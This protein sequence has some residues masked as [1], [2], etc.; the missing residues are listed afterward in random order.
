MI[1]MLFNPQPTV[2]I[3]VRPD[4][5]LVPESYSG[6]YKRSKPSSP[7]LHVNDLQPD[8]SKGGWGSFTA[9]M[10][11]VTGGDKSFGVFGQGNPDIDQSGS[12]VAKSALQKG[13]TW[14]LR[15]MDSTFCSPKYLAITVLPKSASYSGQSSQTIQ[16]KMG[17][18]AWGSY[19]FDPPSQPLTALNL[20][21]E[22]T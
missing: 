19:S 10:L 9:G 18:Y 5:P 1:E 16:V 15:T 20:A 21:E 8:F 7:P 6:M 11:S 2:Q 12:P 22:V 13:I 3:P 4:K 14:N 17:S